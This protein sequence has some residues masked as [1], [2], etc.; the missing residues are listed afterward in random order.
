MSKP[1]W[2]YH[3]DV[4]DAL[5][6][7]MPHLEKAYKILSEKEPDNTEGN[8]QLFSLFFNAGLTKLYHSQQNAKLIGDT[9]A[10]KVTEE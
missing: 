4:A 1:I 10:Q 7:A 2:T 9:S 8:H 6:L 3:G 5:E